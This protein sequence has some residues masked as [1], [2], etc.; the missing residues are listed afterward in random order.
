M[1]NKSFTVDNQV[2][3]VGGRN[4]GDEYFEAGTAVAFADSRHGR[5]RRRRSRRLGA[6]RRLLE[7]RFGLSARRLHAGGGRSRSPRFAMRWSRLDASPE[8]PNTSTP[9]ARRRSCSSSSPAKVESSGC[10]HAW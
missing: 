5:R 8:A 9:C 4:I 7:Q 3:I 1:H 10:R 6:V 2:S